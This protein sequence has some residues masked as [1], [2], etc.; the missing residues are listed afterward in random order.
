MFFVRDGCSPLLPFLQ[1]THNT[2]HTTPHTP[3]TP[4]RDTTDTQP[5]TESDRH[6]QKDDTDKRRGGGEPP[7]LMWTNDLYGLLRLIEGDFNVTRD[8][9]MWGVV[10]VHTKAEV[11]NYKRGHQG[12]Q[13]SQKIERKLT[14]AP[15]PW[16][17]NLCVRGFDA[18][19]Q[20]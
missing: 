16:I 1:P 12:T 13:E 9:H 8:P 2:H 10:F 11:G 15:H 17:T 14:V 19:S 20:L 6:R 18:F 3:F 7:T 4:T 5:D